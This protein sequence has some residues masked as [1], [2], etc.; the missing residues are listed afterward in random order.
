ME[1]DAGVDAGLGRD[2][3]TTTDAGA[4]PDGGTP[5]DAGLFRPAREIV[6]GSG[7]LRGGTLTLDAQ[8]GH[9]I[10]QGRM[11]SGSMTLE[12]NAAAKP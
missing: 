12:G 1:D 3:G 8:V 4:G 11:S 5:A 6:A 10:A 7:T 9:A 2:A